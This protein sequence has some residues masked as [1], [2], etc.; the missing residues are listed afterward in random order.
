MKKKIL[1][2]VSGLA[3]GEYTEAANIQGGDAG[4]S[5]DISLDG[6]SDITVGM[7]VNNNTNKRKEQ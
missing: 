5:A 7:Y 6:A 2:T 3:A 4:S 1:Q